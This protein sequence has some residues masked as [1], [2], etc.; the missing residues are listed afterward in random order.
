[1]VFR[2]SILSPSSGSAQPVKMD[3]GCYTETVIFT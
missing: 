1:M 2:R 3:G